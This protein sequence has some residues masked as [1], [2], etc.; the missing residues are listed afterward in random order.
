MVENYRLHQIL[1]NVTVLCIFITAADN[2]ECTQS[3]ASTL[4]ASVVTHR[5][6]SN[7]GNV[8]ACDMSLARNPRR[9]TTNVQS[10][11]S[12]FQTRG[13]ESLSEPDKSLG[14]SS[15][16]FGGD[17]GHDQLSLP[18]STSQSLGS[19]AEP[20]NHG[21]LLPSQQE[22]IS[23][24]SFSY[25]DSEQVHDPPDSTVQESDIS[26]FGLNAG[27]RLCDTADD[28]NESRNS[29]EPDCNDSV[30]VHFNPEEFNFNIGKVT[31]LSQ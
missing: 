2:P 8:T 17:M 3:E 27:T 26:G 1:T 19:G 12:S 16:D 24:E 20:F 5:P 25:V 15:G 18:S 11:S 9:Q 4:Q 21:C 28:A 23:S 6:V 29:L 14:S 31:V 13:H 10:I 30:E 22:Q 7:K